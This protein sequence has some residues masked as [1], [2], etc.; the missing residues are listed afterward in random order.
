MAQPAIVLRSASR[1]DLVLLRDFSN[2]G[3]PAITRRQQPARRPPTVASAAAGEGARRIAKRETR[4][5][6]GIPRPPLTLAPPAPS[7]AI[8]SRPHNPH[9]AARGTAIGRLA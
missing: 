5:P 6:P 8:S 1:G 3:R 9:N 7:F 4:S 2:R